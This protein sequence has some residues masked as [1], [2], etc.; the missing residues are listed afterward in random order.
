VAALAATLPASE[1]SFGAVDYVTLVAGLLAMV[2][3]YGAA[4]QLLNNNAA[5]G[6]WRNR[7]D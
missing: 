7:H 5:I 4:N 3:L 2:L 1:R 6:T